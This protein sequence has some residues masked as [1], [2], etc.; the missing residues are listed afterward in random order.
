[1]SEEYRQRVIRQK[2]ARLETP[3]RQRLAGVLATGFPQLDSA[4]GVGGLPRGQIVELFG[5]SSGGKTTLA[6]QIA[7]KA[8]QDGSTAAWIDAEHAFDPAYAA[9]LGVALEKLLLARPD[10]AEQALG[11]A[12]ELALSGAVDLVVVDSAAALVPRVELETGL[13]DSGPGLQSRVLGSELRKLAAAVGKC[14][15]AVLFLNQVRSRPDESDSTAGGPSLKLYAAIRIALEPAGGGQTAF[16]ILKNKVAQP[17][18]KGVLR[19]AAPHGFS[20]TP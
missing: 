20:K 16:R 4:L 5:A 9:A 11:I 14:S 2:V 8:Q 17:F 10:S 19:R 15:A 6:L 3:P 7:A 18:S 1:M 12:R 13:G